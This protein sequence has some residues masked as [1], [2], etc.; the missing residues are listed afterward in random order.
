MK[1]KINK[2]NIINNFISLHKVRTGRIGRRIFGARRIGV[3]G[4]KGA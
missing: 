1:R 3:L 4:R 2:M